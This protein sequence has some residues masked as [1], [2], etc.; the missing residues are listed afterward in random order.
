LETAAPTRK[1]KLTF[2]ALS[3]FEIIGLVVDEQKSENNLEGSS[4]LAI[5]SRFLIKCHLKQ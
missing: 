5:D 1:P 4:L 2:W 3:S